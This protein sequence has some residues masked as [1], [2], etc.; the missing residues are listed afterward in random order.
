MSSSPLRHLQRL[1]MT[2][3]HVAQR[4]PAPPHDHRAHAGVYGGMS[5]RFQVASSH[6]QL[7]DSA[8]SSAGHA[9][10]GTTRQVSH[11]KTDA[12]QCHV[13]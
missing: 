11:L 8:A 10:S 6:S 5:V 12:M 13:R 7:S 1:H 9:E 2:L 3:R 4:L